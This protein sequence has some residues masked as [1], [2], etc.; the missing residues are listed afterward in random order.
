MQPFPWVAFVVGALVAALSFGLFVQEKADP[1]PTRG[2]AQGPTSATPQ[3][4]RA[5]TAAE[6]LGFKLGTQAWT[7]RDRTSFEAIDAAAALGLKYIELYPGQAL[8]PDARN[9]QVGP[10]MGKGNVDLLKKKLAASK[11][12]ALS[13]GVV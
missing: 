7:F 2:P 9:V 3:S 4:A 1:D 13:F 10:D 8:S 12:R 5:D 11:V 6:K